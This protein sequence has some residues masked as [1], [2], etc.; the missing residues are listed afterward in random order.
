[1]R[2]PKSIESVDSPFTENLHECNLHE[3]NVFP[4]PQIL[5]FNQEEEAFNWDVTSYPQRQQLINTLNPYL[6]LYETTVE[7]QNKYK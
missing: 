3:C 1:M 7:F 4:F 5:A 6:K 2:G